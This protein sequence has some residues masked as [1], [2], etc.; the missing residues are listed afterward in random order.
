MKISIQSN[1]LSDTVGLETSYAMI[2]DAGFDGVDAG[3]N[4]FWK[5]REVQHKVIPDI[6]KPGM[7][8]KDF[9]DFMHPRKEYAKKYGLS[10]FQGH[11]VY[12]SQLMDNTVDPEYDDFLLDVLRKSILAAADI[13]CENLVIH[14]FYK[15]YECAYLPNEQFERNVERYGIL[16]KTAKET[17]VRIC[18]ENMFV[19]H[20]GR[21][22]KGVCNNPMEAAQYV[23]ALNEQAGE[24]CFGFCFD[25]GHSVFA[26]YDPREFFAY[27]GDRITCTHLHDNNGVEDLHF[28]PFTGVVDWDRLVEGMRLTGYKGPL[29]FETIGAMEDMPEELQQVNL[30]YIADCGRLLSARVEA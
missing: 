8:D 4:R 24:K 2:K 11:A 1:G 17:G 29:N 6:L 21:R 3:L 30:Q 14:P 15:K 25:V 20:N 5:N 23:D 26:G 28:A 22:Y 12:Q 19:T 13:E 27:M 9:I 18:L 10:H 7:T 16:A